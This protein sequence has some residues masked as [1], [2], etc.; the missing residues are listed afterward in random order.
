MLSGLGLA[1]LFVGLMTTPPLSGVLIM[2]SLAALLLGLG[3]ASGYQIIARR[4]RPAD[5][6]RGPSP[7]L[8]F[9]LQFVLVNA[10][11]LVLLTLGLP[12]G[13]AQ[14][15]PL[16]FFAAT[17]VLLAGYLLVVW[18]FGVRAGAMTWR[19]MGFLPHLGLGRFLGDIGLGAAVMFGVALIAGILGSLVAQLLGVDE[20]V[21]VPAPSTAAD[22][23]L[24]ALGAGL[25]V[26]IGEEI[27]FRGY[28]L[29]AWWRDLGSRAAL[30]RTTVFFA[31]LHIV[32][33]SSSTFDE[34]WRQAVL[35]LA[36]ILPVGFALGWLF[37][38]R[39]L[40]A[41]IAGH[42]A[43]NLFAVLVLVMQQYLPPPPG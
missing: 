41:S 43:F 2:G 18:L 9:G 15:S 10:V 13:D 29:T 39:G 3:A 22:I 36:V 5:R 27:F 25:L 31:L 17:V 1:A 7:L 14:T 24:V 26:P 33:I 34:G 37:M 28:A 35:V 19:D 38:R 16:G 21:V 23:A 30:V 8:L 40:V 42:A 4:S 11:S 12:L 6:F 32:Q 20:P